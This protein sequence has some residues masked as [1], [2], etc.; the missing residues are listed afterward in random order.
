VSTANDIDGNEVRVG[1]RLVCV[2]DGASFR[3]LQAGCEYIAEAAYDDTPV[4][5]AGGTYHSIDR[6][7]VVRP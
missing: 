4:V 3:R 7:R 5:I 1:T 6:F 2:D